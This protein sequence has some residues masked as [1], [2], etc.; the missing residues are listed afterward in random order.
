MFYSKQLEICNCQFLFRPSDSSAKLSHVDSEQH[1]IC[2]QAT[3][4]AVSNCTNK[5]NV[6]N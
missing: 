6:I 4:S 3:N 5:S 2:Q 1:S